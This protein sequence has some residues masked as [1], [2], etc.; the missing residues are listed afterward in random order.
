MLGVYV[1]KVAD[2]WKGVSIGLM[3]PLEKVMGNTSCFP[4][5]GQLLHK[6]DLLLVGIEVVFDPGLLSFALSPTVLWLST[7][8]LQ[9]QKTTPVWE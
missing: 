3:Q 6:P 9:G 7:Q 1:R 8:I 4:L 2:F 5:L